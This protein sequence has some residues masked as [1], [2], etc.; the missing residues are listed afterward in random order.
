MGVTAFFSR[1]II[2]PVLV[3]ERPP[4][5]A[6]CSLALMLLT[7]HYFAILRMVICVKVFISSTFAARGTGLYLSGIQ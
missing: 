3:F 6:K 5:R 7:V 1:H 4:Y 2:K